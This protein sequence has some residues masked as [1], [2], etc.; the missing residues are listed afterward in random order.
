MSLIPW[1]LY[2]LQILPTIILFSSIIL[3]QQYYNP[4]SYVNWP[5]WP[6]SH[7][8]DYSFQRDYIATFLWEC[9][10][11]PAACHWW[12]IPAVAVPLTK[13]HHRRRIIGL[14]VFLGWLRGGNLLLLLPEA[15]PEEGEHWAQHVVLALGG[16]NVVSFIRED[17][18]SRM[19]KNKVLFV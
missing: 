14:V 10:Y 7:H 9:F 19:S 11:S 15:A 2:M 8:A 3:Q 13:P 1:Q 16:G 6:W 17:L 5:S 4:S 18:S 12:L